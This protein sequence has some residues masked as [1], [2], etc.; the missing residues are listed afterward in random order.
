MAVFDTAVIAV[1]STERLYTR[2][3]MDL[4]MIGLGR[5]GGNMTE[6]L[7]KAGHRIVVHDLNTAAMDRAAQKGAAK[8]DSL[9]ALVKLHRP[10]RARHASRATPGR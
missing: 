8:A 6:R 5:M 10:P 2:E 3:I 1:S 7:L 9:E 4:G